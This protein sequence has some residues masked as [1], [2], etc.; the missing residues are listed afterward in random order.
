MENKKSFNKEYL[1]DLIKKIRSFLFLIISNSNSTPKIYP[2]QRNKIQLF[3]KELHYHHFNG[4]ISLEDCMML[5]C[6]LDRFDKSDFILNLKYINNL[7]NIFQILEEV[8]V[9]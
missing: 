3:I 5:I 4:S 7:K 8:Y 2:D 1:I 9:T 6:I